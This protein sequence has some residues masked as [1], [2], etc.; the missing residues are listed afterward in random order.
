M[1]KQ[2]TQPPTAQL[3][4]PRLTEE[5]TGP[6][7]PN[8]CQSCGAEDRS[9]MK[10]EG[11]GTKRFEEHD[12]MDQPEHRI[13]VLCR[14]CQRDLIDAHPRLYRRLDANEP[15]PG[16]M[17]LCLDCRHRTG[18]TCAHPTLKANGGTGLQITTR[19]PTTAHINLGR[20]RGYW[21]RLYPEAPT[22]CARKE[23]TPC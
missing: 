20:G 11:I 19:R 9:A 3:P 5:L 17:D 6:R 16:C 10:A 2:R 13:V 23:T 4:W 15:W 18:V 1:K 8:L 7:H 14:A 21:T 12:D 22:A